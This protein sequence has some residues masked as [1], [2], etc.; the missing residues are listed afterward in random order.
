MRMATKKRIFNG[1]DELDKKSVSFLLKAIKEN[2]LPGFDYIE[3]KQSLNALLAMDMDAYTAIKSAFTTASTMGL[4]KANLLGSA[5]HYIQIL[6]SEK[7]QF[8]D[9]LNK[10]M[11]SKVDGK[12]EQ[13]KVLS[14]KIEDY[15][16]K[17]KQL[18]QEIAKYQEKLDNADEEI[19][20]A[21]TKIEN[22]KVKFEETFE[23]MLSEIEN[24]ITTIK[25]T[26]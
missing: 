10:Q 6:K 15:R 5:E 1:L 13:K 20:A 9:A 24:D 14:G 25:E 3:F 12:Q 8:D 23:H 4:T 18:E 16:Q 19:E 26:L 7:S 22:T 2:N 21:R 11:A 17:I